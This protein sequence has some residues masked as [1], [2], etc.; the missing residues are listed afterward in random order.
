MSSLLIRQIMTVCFLSIIFAGCQRRVDTT[1]ST[2][3]T[4]EGEHVCAIVLD[5][6]GSF[7]HRMA[8]EGEGFE[9][10]TAV[11]D[12]YFRHSIGSSNRIIIAHISGSS[13]AMLWE[14]TPQQLRLEFQTPESFRDFLMSN[15]E[16]TS[17]NVFESLERTINYVANHQLVQNGAE[18]ALFVLSDME[19]TTGADAQAKLRVTNA[20]NRLAERNGIVGMY[21]VNQLFVDGWKSELSN[22]GVGDFIVESQIVGRPTL[23]SFDS[24]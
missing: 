12:S 3:G 6:S 21:Y 17:S 5:L 16:F 4:P 8:E 14:G 22:A 15:A 19:D 1:E 11:L 13:E 18:P 24:F 7:A 20:I 9:F 10:A 2:F 23:P